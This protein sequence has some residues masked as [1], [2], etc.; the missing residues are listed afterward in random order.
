MSSLYTS[1]Y[2][3]LIALITHLG[4][5]NKASRTPT[6]I[7]QD[8]QLEM[9]EVLDTLTAF[10]AYF[11]QSRK[12][13]SDP[14]SKGDHYFTLHLRYSRR[15]TAQKHGE[16]SQPLSTDEIHMLLSLVTHM[17]E[18]EQAN[19][20]VYTGLEKNYQ[21]L[22]NSNRVT[23]YAAIIAAFIAAIGAIIAAGFK[24]S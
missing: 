3:R 14:K 10:P 9:Q 16:A 2:S 6:F 11:R 19:E 21:S 4:A 12:T 15:A 18:Q 22:D 24:A 1:H 13:S 8:L 20:R 5:T 23:M 17:L 7:A